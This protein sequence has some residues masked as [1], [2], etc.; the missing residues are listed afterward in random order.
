[1]AGHPRPLAQGR[2]CG[3]LFR[4]CLCLPLFLL[5]VCPRTE[6]SPETG[7]A[8]MVDEG[9][10]LADHQETRPSRSGLIVPL[11]ERGCLESLPS[12]GL[13]TQSAGAKGRQTGQTADRREGRRCQTRGANHK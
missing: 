13:L 2:K 9:V 1:M 10:E 5:C 4:R 3:S 8:W 7:V 12:L 6:F 11:A